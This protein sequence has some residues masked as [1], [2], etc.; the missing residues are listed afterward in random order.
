MRSP[1]FTVA[2]EAQSPDDHLAVTSGLLRSA[3]HE[4]SQEWELTYNLT[5]STPTARIGDREVRVKH[6]SRC[7]NQS[8][9]V[10]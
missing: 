2:P 3:S 9:V 4:A 1:P 8:S 7:S 6:D 10:L 5:V